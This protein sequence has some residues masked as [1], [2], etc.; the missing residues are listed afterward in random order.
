MGDLPNIGAIPLPRIKPLRVL[1]IQDTCCFTSRDIGY[2]PFYFQ[3]YRI[4]L[5]LL[6][7]IW[8]SVFNNLVYFQGYCI[9]RKNNYGD[10]CQ[11]ISDT[12]MFPLRDFG[13]LVPPYKA[14]QVC[15]SAQYIQSHCSSYTHCNTL[16]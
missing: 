8:D 15:A 7:G 10:V 5:N 12:G 16:K 6:P 14:S 4:L 11:F 2:Y 13:Y 1:G 9:F 3:G